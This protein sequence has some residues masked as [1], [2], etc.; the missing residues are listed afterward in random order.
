MEKGM[1]MAND[2]TV[3][4]LSREMQIVIDD[5]K[6]IGIRVPADR[7]RGPILNSRAHSFLGRC[8]KT[9]NEYTIELSADLLKGD[10]DAIRAILFHELLH[11]M[12][13]CMNHGVKWKGYAEKVKQAYGVTVSR[14]SR[15]EEHGLPEREVAPVRYELICLGC[16]TIIG[17][18][19]R[20]SLVDHPERY[21]CAKCGGNLQIKKR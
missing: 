9:G 21:R 7:I 11:T 8:H 18:K 6:T 2:N 15:R 13:G 16:G 4:W 3:I 17:R 12:P 14:I 5:L 1:Q 20:C 10:K 19:R